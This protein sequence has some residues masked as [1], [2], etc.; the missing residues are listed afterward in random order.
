MKSTD[1]RKLFGTPIGAS[2]ASGNIAAIPQIQA[3][4]GDGTASVAL[5][6][7]PE[8][9]IA[10]AAGGEPPRGQDMNGLLN[11]LS[12][13][14]QVLQAGYLGAFDASFAQGIG[15]YPAG[16]IVA[17]SAPG[18]FWV[19]MADANVATPG[20]EGAA[21]Q[22]LFSGYATQAWANGQFLQLA[23][24]AEQAVVGPVTFSG[25]TKVPTPTDYSQKQAI[26]ASDADARYARL[27]G[28]NTFAS[29]QTINNGPLRIFN[30]SIYLINP[31]GEDVQIYTDQKGSGVSD[32][33]LVFRTNTAA[34]PVYTTFA[35]TGRI[36]SSAK[37]DVAFTSQLPTA[38]GISGGYYKKTPI[39]GG[40]FLLSQMFLVTAANGDRVSFPLAYS[41]S[42]APPQL[43]MATNHDLDLGSSVVDAAGFTLLVVGSG[44]APVSVYVEGVVQA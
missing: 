32:N 41:T 16:A 24:A 1:D 26:G 5:G 22:S 7:P 35:S 13:A 30:G 38:G 2:A 33:D 11:L 28:E 40:G 18:A 6:F 12:S 21:W 25:I 20:A 14:V 42:P 4:A 3:T 37:G 19:S 44:T 31:S 10:R 17:G 27:S 15:G 43:T 23:N 8:T 39:A 29:A 36:Y 34:S 9:F